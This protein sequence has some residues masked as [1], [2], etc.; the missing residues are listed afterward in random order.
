MLPYR[1]PFPHFEWLGVVNLNLARALLAL[2]PYFSPVWYHTYSPIVGGVVASGVSWW[3]SHLTE[4]KELAKLGS[5]RRAEALESPP[6]PRTHVHPN[7]S[8]PAQVS[9]GWPLLNASKFIASFM[10]T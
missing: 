4:L 8:G 10:G 1:A 5:A 7:L 2:W 9:S 6:P 3:R